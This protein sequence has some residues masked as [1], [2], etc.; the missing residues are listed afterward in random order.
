MGLPHG[1]PAN[2]ELAQKLRNTARARA[3]QLFHSQLQQVHTEIAD[4]AN[5]ASK[6]KAKGAGKAAGAKPDG[7]KAAEASA[8]T[9]GQKPAAG[10]KK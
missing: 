5:K 8:G 7:T 2:P 3:E 9:L 1:D 6:E 4:K 10:K